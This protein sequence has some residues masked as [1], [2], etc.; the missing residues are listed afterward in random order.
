[1]EKM[2]GL[3]DLDLEAISK[4]G[5]I[6]DNAEVTLSDD[7]L[8]ELSMELDKLAGV[9][10]APLPPRVTEA[11]IKAKKMEA[12]AFKKAGK[13]SEA[14]VALKEAKAMEEEMSA[15]HKVIGSGTHSY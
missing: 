13:I 1:M 9:P 12:L 6:D 15:P 2:E 4:I 3:G 7:D 8:G 10:D 14:R 5:L 11:D